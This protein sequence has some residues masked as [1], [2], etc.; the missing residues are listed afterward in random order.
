M[1]GLHMIHLRVAA[2]AATDCSAVRRNSACMFTS[3]GLTVIGGFLVLGM[4][5]H[6]AGETTAWDGET[7]V[8]SVGE[9]EILHDVNMDDTWSPAPDLVVRVS[10]YDPAVSREIHR[11]ELANK[12][13]EE[14][15]RKVAPAR[16][17]LRQQQRE[18]ARERV[19]PLTEQQAERLYLLLAEVGDI[20][21]K[22]R[23]VCRGCP[24]GA[25]FET[26]HACAKC[27]QLELLQWRKSESER[28]PV[29]PLTEGQLRRL[30]NLE[31]EAMMLD[32][33]IGTT[34][35]EVAN[36]KRLIHGASREIETDRLI[37]DFT[38]R[39]V[40]RVHPDDELT[41]S[42]WDDDVFNDDLYGQTIVT[43][44]R[45]TLEHGTL[46]VSMLPN[47]KF[48]RLRF[49]RDEMASMP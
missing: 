31:E 3:T 24:E 30:E 20:C 18:S 13:R 45:T 17:E 37:V 2:Y 47:I 14:R 33:E 9:M 26:C 22:S 19:E 6:G 49:R 16:D 38:G 41:I 32:G 44:D 7:Y 48:V 8:L 1:S 42:V 40:I 35:E 28:V 15:R 10:R 25:D 39:D 27:P 12:G 4:A 29:P 36:L 5:A 23:S 43:L 11:L 46:D 34:K 21:G